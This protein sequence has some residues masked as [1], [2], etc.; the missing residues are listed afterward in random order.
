[1]IKNLANEVCQAEN[2]C[3]IWKLFRNF[4]KIDE[5]AAEPGSPLN[6]PDGQYT[7]NDRGKLSEFARH[8]HT[9]H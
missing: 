8:M 9:A 7:F 3:S 6:C 5:P 4:K 2:L 1:M